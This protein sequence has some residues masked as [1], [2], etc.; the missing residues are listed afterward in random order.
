MSIIEVL[1][2]A[3]VSLSPT[4]LAEIWGAKTDVEA[5]ALLGRVAALGDAEAEP[6]I[7]LWLDFLYETLAFGKARSFSAVKALATLDIIKATAVH[8][9]D[10]SA[11]GDAE[12]KAACLRFL[13]AAVLETTKRMAPGERFSL[14][15]VEAIMAHARSAVINHV[16]LLRLAFVCEQ[17]SSRTP[18]RGWLGAGSPCAL[19]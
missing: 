8:A 12:P 18:P 9:V 14:T 11:S 16:R 7:S 3:P 15:D 10:A 1:L 5:V 2:R 13:S 19:L 4:Q 17:V 6:R